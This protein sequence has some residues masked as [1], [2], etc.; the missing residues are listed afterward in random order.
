MPFA[1]TETL[2]RLQVAQPFLGR[3]EIE[4]R[5]GRPYRAN[6]GANEGLFGTSPRA[7]AVLAERGTGTVLYGDPF[8]HDLRETIA[9]AWRRS[10][11]HIVIE[12]GIEGLLALFV[13]A[14][15]ATLR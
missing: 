7:L 6:L 15:M 10:R 14:F 5:R 11:A 4:R 3:W 12:N 8:L 13:R 1:F 2:S 9:A